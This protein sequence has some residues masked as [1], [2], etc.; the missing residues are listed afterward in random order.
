VPI[1]LLTSYRPKAIYP[2]DGRQADNDMSAELQYTPADL[3]DDSQILNYDCSDVKHETIPLVSSEAETE[4]EG[5]RVKKEQQN[6]QIEKKRDEN[7]SSL[8]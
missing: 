6:R 8:L 2:E 4:R 1:K 3:R 5:K 7:V